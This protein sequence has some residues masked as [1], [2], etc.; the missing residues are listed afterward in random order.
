M[1]EILTINLG[2]GQAVLAKVA[3]EFK[4]SNILFANAIKNADRACP[5]ARQAYDF[6]A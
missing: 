6:A 4:E 3:G 1:V 2:D 5:F